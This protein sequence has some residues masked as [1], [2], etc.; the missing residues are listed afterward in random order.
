[1]DLKEIV[2]SSDISSFEVNHSG[3]VDALLMY[4]TRLD[5]QFAEVDRNQRLRNFIRVFANCPVRWREIIELNYR[6]LNGEELNV[7]FLLLQVNFE[8]PVNDRDVTAFSALVNKLNCCISQLEQFPVKVHDLPAGAGS[9]TALKFFNTHQLKVRHSSCWPCCREKL[10]VVH[11]ELPYYLWR[12]LRLH[13]LFPTL[14]MYSFRSIGDQRVLL[15]NRRQLLLSHYKI[16][17]FTNIFKPKPKNWALWS[18]LQF[19]ASSVIKLFALLVMS[20]QRNIVLVSPGSSIF[21]WK[22]IFSS[23]SVELLVISVSVRSF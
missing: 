20:E 6:W 18:L 2:L 1:M 10:C 14:Q 19:S 8:V 5:D 9:T 13:F 21:C 4:L 11:E 22:L 3:M 12:F 23:S 7:P 16:V 17:Q 15:V